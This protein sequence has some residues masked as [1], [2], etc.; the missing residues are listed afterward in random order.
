M[1]VAS[2][3]LHAPRLMSCHFTDGGGK[4]VYILIDIC[5]RSDGIIAVP[6]N[7]LNVLWARAARCEQR[8]AGVPCAVRRKIVRKPEGFHYRLPNLISEAVLARFA[9]PSV[10]KAAMPTA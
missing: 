4:R 8:S 3:L 7:A 10:G 1:G 5:V 2:R 6:E 9:L